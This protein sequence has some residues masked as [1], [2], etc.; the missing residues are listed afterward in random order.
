MLAEARR[1]ATAR[2]AAQPN[3]GYAPAY[4]PGAPDLASAAAIEVRSGQITQIEFRLRSQPVYEVKGVVT[5][6]PP[7]QRGANLQFFN[8]SGDTLQ[9]DLRFNPEDGSFSAKLPAGTY[10]VVA[11]FSGMRPAL[12]ASSTIVVAGNLSGIRIPA[13][14]GTTIPIVVRTEFTTSPANT[15]GIAAA[16]LKDRG[17]SLNVFINGTNA[18]GAAAHDSAEFD[19]E[20]QSLSLRDVQPGRY[21]ADIQPRNG[22]MYVASAKYGQTDL[23]REELV[24]GQGGEQRAIEVVLRDDFAMV[25]GSVVSENNAVDAI[26]LLL[27]DRGPASIRG[28]SGSE[29]GFTIPR[30]APADY[31]LFAF[32]S[33]DGLEYANPEA[34]EPY[35]SRATR[36]TLSSRGTANVTLTLIKR[37]EP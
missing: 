26:V 20:T 19:D 25:S 14:A 31:Q 24:V 23:L 37:G 3:A 11:S 8:R 35:A 18:A 2:A 15:G 5:G 33:I 36:V 30:L 13:V 29:R 34:L 7:G 9:A 10:T 12:T 28:Q 22:L 16:A 4:Y 27:P 32:D 21:V 17:P 1:P 6:L